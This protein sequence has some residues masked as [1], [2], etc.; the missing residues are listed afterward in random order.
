MRKLTALL[1]ALVVSA[2]ATAGC[3]GASATADTDG[4]S[5]EALDQ[6]TDALLLFGESSDAGDVASEVEAPRPQER[7]ID[8]GDPMTKGTRGER[9]R[10]LQEALEEL[11][12]SPGEIDGIFGNKTARAVGEFQGDRG[13]PVTRVADP[14]TIAAI[15]S[16]L[17]QRG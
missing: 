6:E 1:A 14:D 17:A 9:V 5:V 10:Q 7:G 2:I 8:D 3:G 16:K 11:G 4:G 15:N 13:L 12:F